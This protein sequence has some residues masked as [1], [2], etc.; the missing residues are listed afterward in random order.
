M[1]ALRRHQYLHFLAIASCERPLNL[2][3]IEPRTVAQTETLHGMPSF[4]AQC[5]A[6]ITPRTDDNLSAS[7]DIKP[8]Q[9]SLMAAMMLATHKHAALLEGGDQLLPCRLVSAFRGGSK[10]W[11]RQ[12]KSQ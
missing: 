2:L 6:A 3:R 1:P 5:L 11:N 9:V 10:P 12:H 7:A 4:M 8:V